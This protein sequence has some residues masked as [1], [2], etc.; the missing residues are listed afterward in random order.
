MR[1]FFAGESRS[2]RRLWGK[3]SNPHRFWFFSVLS[4]SI[5]ASFFEVASIGLVA[6]LVLFL[7]EGSNDFVGPDLLNEIFFQFFS[8]PIESN[9]ILWA[10]AIVAVLAG[11]MRLALLWSSLK[12]TNKVTKD[13]GVKLFQDALNEDFRLLA[14]KNSSEVISAIVQKV[15]VASGVLSAILNAATSTILG[16]AI[17]LSLIVH[18]AELAFVAFSIFGGFYLIVI[19]IFESRLRYNSELIADEQIRVLKC[20][21]EAFG[22]IR[23]VIIGGFKGV[24]IN[25]FEVSFEKQ[26][27]ANKS[28]GFLS[29][30]PRYIIETLAL[31]SVAIFL[32]FSE[33]NSEATKSLLPSI[34][35]LAFG[36]QRLLPL[37]QQIYGNLANISA[38]KKSL[39]D[40]LNLMSSFTGNGLS[41]HNAKKIVD[42][43]K[44]IKIEDV[45]FGYNQ[46]VPVLKGANL[47]IKPGDRVGI[48]GVTGGGKSTLL[49]I[50]MGLLPPDVGTLSI[51]GVEVNAENAASWQKLFAH[52]PQNTFIFDTT[53]FE[54]IAVGET[55]ETLDK[56]R[57]YEAVRQAQIFDHFNSLPEGFMTTLGERGGK[58]S[59]GQMQRIGIARALYQ[60]RRI[61][62]FDEPTN[63]L[64]PATEAQVI[65]TIN[66]LSQNMTIVIVS[67]NNFPLKICDNIY[68]VDGGHISKVEGKSIDHLVV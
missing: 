22:S 12:L 21:R 66:N 38:G 20:L 37:L 67:H 59:G 54:N 36:A 6:P 43:E 56:D 11:V 61:L 34:A 7:L 28:S 50:I 5:F 8:R 10:F 63:A 62:F 44:S 24:Y 14:S 25:L 33:L 19:F 47:E 15:A 55:L 2:V 31:V 4:L 13:L 45:S 42:F 39:D 57:V 64:D 30:S 9:D 41:T 60:R 49:D 1:F 3:I 65:S 18:N 51:D 46:E 16:L 68:R 35:V 17:A 32:I 52:V 40:V 29:Q 23:Q 58:L 53:V 48:I 26:H 27:E